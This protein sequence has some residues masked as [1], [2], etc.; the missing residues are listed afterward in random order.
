M[1]D[2]MNEWAWLHPFTLLFP[3]QSSLQ[4]SLLIGWQMFSFP[5]PLQMASLIWLPVAVF[6]AGALLLSVSHTHCTRLQ[7]ASTV[8]TAQCTK[9]NTAPSIQRLQLCDT[10][11]DTVF[12]LLTILSVFCTTRSRTQNEQRRKS[13]LVARQNR[14]RSELCHFQKTADGTWALAGGTNL[15]FSISVYQVCLSV[16]ACWQWRW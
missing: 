6:G 4:F 5:S 10:N 3:L 15:S 8:H 16:S 1:N 2:W 7:I 11:T 14:A 13:N 9:L 12:T